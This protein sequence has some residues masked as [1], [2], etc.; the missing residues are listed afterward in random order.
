MGRSKTKD[1]GHV[2]GDLEFRDSFKNKKLIIDYSN[3]SVSDWMPDDVTY[4]RGPVKLG[5]LKIGGTKPKPEFQF[6]EYSAAMIDPFWQDLKYSKG[7]ESEPGSLGANRAGRI[8][9]MP[10]FIL[11]DGWVH[12]LA[13]GKAK[14]YS[15]VGAHIMICLLYTSPS[16]RDRQKSPMPSSA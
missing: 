6:V 16:P 14:I 15:S 11:E 4:G 3:T 13:K 12:F 10:S 5:A 8:L 2:V 1:A 7:A 9:S